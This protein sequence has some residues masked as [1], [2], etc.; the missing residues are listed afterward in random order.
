MNRSFWCL[1]AMLFTADG[2]LAASVSECRGCNPAQME[3]RALQRGAG[4]WDVWN[5]V[6]GEISR[7]RVAC[8]VAPQGGDS[9]VRS[10]EVPLPSR[11]DASP[12]AGC[13]NRIV[14]YPPVPLEMI[15]TA[16]RLSQIYHSTGGTYKV[17][18]TVR[19][20]DVG[21]LLADGGAPTAHDFLTDYAYRGRLENLITQRALGD[22]ANPLASLLEWIFAHADAALGFTGAL[23]LLVTVQFDD[24]STIQFVI[25]L[26]HPADY[27]EGSA[28]DSGGVPLPEENS[29]RYQ[30]RFRFDSIENYS[31]FRW[32]MGRLGA[33]QIGTGHNYYT[34]IYDCTWDGQ[35]LSCSRRVITP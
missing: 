1:L 30:G 26:N 28:R 24:G 23:E 25:T 13:T 32:L 5:P 29:S 10:P 8:G 15:D 18:I 19:A 7:Y 4:T 12:S 34:D 14:D 11:S 20:R 21:V 17:G 3:Q 22:A 27:I 16:N 33:H 9:S 6:N 31:R 2:A 35:T